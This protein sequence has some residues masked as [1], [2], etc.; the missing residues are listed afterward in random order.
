MSNIII[1]GGKDDILDKDCKDFTPLDDG[2]CGDKK[3]CALSFQCKQIGMKSDFVQ[4]IDPKT[5]QVGEFDY[6]C[7]GKYVVYE[8]RM[9]DEKAN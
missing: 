8:E 6:L 3:Y 2:L 1:K 4:T 5:G 7:T 9:I